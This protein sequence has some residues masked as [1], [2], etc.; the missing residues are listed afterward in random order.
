MSNLKLLQQEYTSFLES[1]YSPTKSDTQFIICKKDGYNCSIFSSVYRVSDHIQN[2]LVIRIS[3]EINGAYRYLY[4]S[5]RYESNS[6][7]N[8]RDSL[9]IPIEMAKRAED[10]LNCLIAF[11]ILTG[12]VRGLTC[13]K[14]RVYSTSSSFEINDRNISHSLEIRLD[15]NTVTLDKE[16]KTTIELFSS[17]LGHFSPIDYVEKRI[18]K[19]EANSKLQSIIQLEK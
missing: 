3:L 2:R 15:N 16:T 10:I 8:A 9:R 6:F 1:N 12:E 7:K 14:K 5:E 18:K 11:E 4:K 13:S 19:D 17:I